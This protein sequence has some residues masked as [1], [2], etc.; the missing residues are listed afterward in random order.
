[1]RKK[2]VLVQ[3]IINARPGHFIHRLELKFDES[4][5]SRIYTSKL[6]GQWVIRKKNHTRVVHILATAPHG[7]VLYELEYNKIRNHAIKEIQNLV[8]L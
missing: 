5:H 7:G 2:N 3:N 4:S 8:T 1:M 6:R